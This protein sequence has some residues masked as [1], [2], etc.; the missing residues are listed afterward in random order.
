M[1][2]TMPD[3]KTSAERMLDELEP[4]THPARDGRHLRKIGAALTALEQAEDNLRAAVN[5]ASAA[6][7]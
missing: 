1:T 4:A 5:E 7:D 2:K 6:G 3:T